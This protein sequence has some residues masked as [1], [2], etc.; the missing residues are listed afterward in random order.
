MKEK[1]VCKAFIVD[2]F[3]SK[4]NYY[5]LREERGDN[6]VY[7]LAEVQCNY[8]MGLAVRFQSCTC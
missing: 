6:I 4:Y 5:P 8:V 2:S 1:E 7:V 3:K